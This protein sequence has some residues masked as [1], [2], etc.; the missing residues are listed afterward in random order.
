MASSTPSLRTA[1]APPRSSAG[2]EAV[3][4]PVGRSGA[5]GAETTH[6]RQRRHGKNAREHGGLDAS[7]AEVGHQALVLRRLEEE[8]GDAEIRQREFGGQEVAVGR[9]IGRAGVARR[10]GGHAD[11][12]ASDGPRQLH[13][14]GGVGQFTGPRIGILGWIATEGHEV[15]HPRLAQRHE[16]VGQL[17]PGVGHADDVGH[18]I[19]VGRVEHAGHEVDRAL[20]GLSP[21]AVG[22][23]DER[24]FEG[25]QL[26]D[27]AGQRGQLLVVL[28]R[29]EFEGV[30]GAGRQQL[31]NQRHDDAPPHRPHARSRPRV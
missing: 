30:G 24:R 11:G 4:H 16:D 22:D 18:G 6:G 20:P 9:Q 27:R 8:L 28:R 31:R 21:A 13:Q 26:P 5:H 7:L 15:L 10:M 14:L 3:L 17:Q 23:R 2:A 12:E 25:L 29:E 1:S 19:E